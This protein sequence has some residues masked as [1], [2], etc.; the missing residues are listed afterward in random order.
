METIRVEG[1]YVCRLEGTLSGKKY[2]TLIVSIQ[3]SGR[4]DR[5]RMGIS[6][7]KP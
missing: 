6:E 5:A 3:R 1:C 2:F 4:R 7:S